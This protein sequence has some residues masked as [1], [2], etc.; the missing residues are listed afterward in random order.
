MLINCDRML[1]EMTF[2]FDFSAKNSNLL[3]KGRT[4]SFY[5]ELID[6]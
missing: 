3:S 6:L 2:L 1:K 5:F 4:I